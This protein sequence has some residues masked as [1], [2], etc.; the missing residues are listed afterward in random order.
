MEVFTT[1]NTF[2]KKEGNQITCK[3]SI[4]LSVPKHCFISNV[5]ILVGTRNYDEIA[6]GQKKIQGL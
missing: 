6:T 4:L 1:R 3:R 2:L 5:V